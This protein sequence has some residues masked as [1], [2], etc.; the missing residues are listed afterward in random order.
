MFQSHGD[1]ITQYSP[2]PNVVFLNGLIGF[3]G[4]A[5]VD[6]AVMKAIIKGFFKNLIRDK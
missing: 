1:R 3:Y 6:T 5:G 2:S 4:Q